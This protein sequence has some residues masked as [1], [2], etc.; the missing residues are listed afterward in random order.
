MNADCGNKF[1]QFRDLKVHMRMHTG[2][3]P[4]QCSEC[5]KMFTQASHLKVHMRMRTGER[6]YECNEC[7]KS[8]LKLII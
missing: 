6:P 2:E 1:T 4:Y 7:G 3:K 5:G 8:L